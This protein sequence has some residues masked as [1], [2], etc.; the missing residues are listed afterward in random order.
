MM[1]GESYEIVEVK[2]SKLTETEMEEI[3]K[4]EI[5]LELLEVDAGIYEFHF[6]GKMSIGISYEQA[7]LET[8]HTVYTFNLFVN[9]E[10]INISGYYDSIYVAV[11]ILTVEWNMAVDEYGDD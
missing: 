10:Y 7:G 1:K 4:T 2:M 8:D 11:K 5:S 3:L 6:D 9:S